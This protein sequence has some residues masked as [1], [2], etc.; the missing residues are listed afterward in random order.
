M[1]TVRFIAM[2]IAALSLLAL[3]SCK[4]PPAPDASASDSTEPVSGE[5]EQTTPLTS[6]E[7]KQTT[8]PSSD[9]EEAAISARLQEMRDML[10]ELY[11]VY[12]MQL[13]SV[14]TYDMVVDVL[15]DTEE[16]A[17]QVRELLQ[18]RGYEE[19]LYNVEVGFV[20]PG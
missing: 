20:Y 8:P 2:L 1:K 6:A 18:E 10:E 11:S 9:E 14:N 5:T 15:V 16:H 3:C 4:V 13:L 7:V 12:G 17:E 19:E